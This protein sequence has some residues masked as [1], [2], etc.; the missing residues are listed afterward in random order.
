MLCF[1][2]QGWGTRVRFGSNCGHCKLRLPANF[3]VDWLPP[4]PTWWHLGQVSIPSAKVSLPVSCPKHVRHLHDGAWVCVSSPMWS[5]PEPS[6]CA[7]LVTLPR[8]VPVLGLEALPD[9]G[10]VS[11]NRSLF[12]ASSLRFS[13]LLAFPTGFQRKAHFPVLLLLESETHPLRIIP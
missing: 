6:S 4:T 3:A 12:M 2:C 1:G 9:P 10:Q 11:G 5:V 13:D 7:R 8:W